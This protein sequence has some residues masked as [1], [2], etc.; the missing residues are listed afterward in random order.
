MPTAYSLTLY[1]QHPVGEK[2]G[3]DML[4]KYTILSI[5]LSNAYSISLTKHYTPEA[6]AHFYFLR[7]CI[8]ICS[9]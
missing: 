8:L 4:K 5:A 3:D 9:Q 6:D 7:Q 2:R 1:M